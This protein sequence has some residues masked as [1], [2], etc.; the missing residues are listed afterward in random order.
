MY[1]IPVSKNTTRRGICCCCPAIIMIMTGLAHSH[2]HRKLMIRK[3]SRDISS[4]FIIS[5]VSSPITNILR[6]C[7][8]IRQPARRIMYI[9]G[10]RFVVI[11]LEILS[12]ADSGPAKQNQPDWMHLGALDVH[13]PAP[14]LPNPSSSQ[15]R[16]MTASQIDSF[17]ISRIYIPTWLVAVDL[18]HFWL[19]ITRFSIISDPAA[20]LYRE[21]ISCMI[22]WSGNNS[23]KRG[24]LWKRE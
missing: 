7:H 12:A 16:W 13:S 21:F 23:K 2:I 15:S 10:R 8:A 11:H 14:A 19:W 5:F 1:L 20:L 18:F 17:G 6:L 9:T 3:V 4:L 24:C 22:G